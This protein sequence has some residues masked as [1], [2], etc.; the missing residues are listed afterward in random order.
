MNSDPI[1]PEP[2]QCVNNTHHVKTFKR[3]GSHLR[4]QHTPMFWWSPWRLKKKRSMCNVTEKKETREKCVFILLDVKKC[5]IFRWWRCILMAGVHCMRMHQHIDKLVDSAEK[6]SS[7]ILQW[8]AVLV[9]IGY[10]IYVFSSSFNSIFFWVGRLHKLALIRINWLAC[11][12][13]VVN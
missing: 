8:L 5:K 7:V 11:H 3:T 1:S 12:Q 13:K 4:S 9:S 6:I 10:C 2:S